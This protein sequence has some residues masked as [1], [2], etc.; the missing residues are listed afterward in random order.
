M[1]TEE[2]RQK[3]MGKAFEMTEKFWQYFNIRELSEI[4]I[5]VAAAYREYRKIFINTPYT[6]PLR[7]YDLAYNSKVRRREFRIKL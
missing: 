6:L 4:P 5:E 1:M 7:K 3:F 2:D